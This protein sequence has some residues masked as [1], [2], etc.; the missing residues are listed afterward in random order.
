MKAVTDKTTFRYNNCVLEGGVGGELDF[1]ATESI[2]ALFPEQ[3]DSIVYAHYALNEDAGKKALEYR[4][5]SLNLCIPPHMVAA[6]AR[7]V[8]YYS[9]FLEGE[10]DMKEQLGREVS[11]EGLPLCFILFQKNHTYFLFAPG[12]PAKTWLEELQQVIR[13]LVTGSR[14]GPGPRNN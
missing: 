2:V 5:R 13:E 3:K 6:D 12:I 7:L 14:Q 4:G 9:D 10:A 1:W 8:Q 11:K